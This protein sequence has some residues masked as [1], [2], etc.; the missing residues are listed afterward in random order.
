MMSKPDQGAKAA[1]PETKPLLAVLSGQRRTPVP[2]WLMRQAGRYLPE[3]HRVRN[4]AP[5]FVDFCLNPDLPA[6]AT[7]Q[8]IRRFGMDAAI[9]FSDIPMVPLG[10]G[11]KL[12]YAEGE[13][14]KLDPIGDRPAIKRLALGG[15]EERLQPIFETVRRVRAALP[16]T[17]T[18]IGFAGAPW[19]I[20]AYMVEGGGSREFVK[21]RRWALAEPDAFQLLIDTLVEATVLYL[22][23][24]IRAGAETVQLFDSWAGI[25]PEAEFRRWVIEP[26]IRIVAALGTRHPHV[27]VIGFPRGAGQLYVDYA[28]E[29]KVAALCL[30]TAVPLAWAARAL[31]DGLA[32]QGNLDPVA[33]LAGGEALEQAVRRVIDAADGRAHIFNLGH[34]VLPPTPPE[35]VATLARLLRREP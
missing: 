5:S 22:D 19:T 29:T 34:G 32:I 23:R 20:A 21:A 2:W 11:Q 9:L 17:V 31:P 13:G 26:T 8:P 24:Q 4:Q 6:E 1:C 28:R 30:D 18:L 10:L 7:L 25:L 14:P 16:E 12:W 15:F 35:H 27:P 3:Y 33:L